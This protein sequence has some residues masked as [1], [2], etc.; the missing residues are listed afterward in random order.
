LKWYGTVDRKE[1]AKYLK[2]KHPE[3]EEKERKP[4]LD[5]QIVEKVEVAP[6]LEKPDFTW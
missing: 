3:L 5:T 4:I 1:L 2:D 6:K